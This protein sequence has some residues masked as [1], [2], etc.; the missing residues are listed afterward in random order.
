MDDSEEKRKVAQIKLRND[1]A[2][3]LVSPDLR[4]LFAGKG[5]N[6]TKVTRRLFAFLDSSFC[7]GMFNTCF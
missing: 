7:K 4:A 5:L 6:L 3:A 2:L 1:I